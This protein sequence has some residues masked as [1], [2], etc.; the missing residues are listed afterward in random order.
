M[1]YILKSRKHLTNIDSILLFIKN[2]IQ[3]IKKKT[4]IR[5]EP[6]SR[7]WRAQGRRMKMQWGLMFGSVVGRWSDLEVAG[8]S[9]GGWIVSK[10]DHLTDAVRFL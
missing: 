2:K 7:K 5:S 8:R 3:E 6:V 9:I 1:G 4:H 10:D